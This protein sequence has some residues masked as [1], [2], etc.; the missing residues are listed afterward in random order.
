M[1]LTAR[2]RYD[3]Y[4]LS[5]LEQ[6][7]YE[8]PLGIWEPYWWANTVLI[9]L[10]VEERIRWAERAMR[11]LLEGGLVQFYRGGWV[12]GDP[13]SPLAADAAVAAIRGD[14]W[15]H[16]PLEEAEVWFEATERGDQRM[17]AAVES[18]EW[19][20]E[21]AVAPGWVGDRTGSCS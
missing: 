4:R 12:S 15:R 17:A 19:V 16:L 10:A 13:S 6:A 2:Q 3:Q 5:I 20:G 8:A 7:C 21:E 1:R 18:R 11:E 9:D 14:A